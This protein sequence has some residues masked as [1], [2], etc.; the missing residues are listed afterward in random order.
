MNTPNREINRFVEF[1]GGNTKAAKL[2]DCSPDMVRK[3]K[4]G[5]RGFNEEIVR[6]MYRC[7]GF[8]LSWLRLYD[9]D[10]RPKE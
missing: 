3:M 10:W 2:L 5:E 4:T 9:L 8:R 7:K 6:A 1:A